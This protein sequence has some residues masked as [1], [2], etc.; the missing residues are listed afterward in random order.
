MDILLILKIVAFLLTF[1]LIIF[2]WL[3]LQDKKLKLF[4]TAILVFF[5]LSIIFF[6]PL[7]HESLEWYKHLLFYIGQIFFYLFSRR[8]IAMNFSFQ[9][10]NASKPISEKLDEFLPSSSK[11]FCV[12]ASAASN[13]SAASTT[14]LSQWFGFLIDQGLLH[15]LTMPLFLLTTVFIRVRY[16]YFESE[17]LKH[18]L[19]FFMLAAGT[20]VMIHVSEFIVESQKLIPVIDPFGEF[21]EMVEFFWF[22]LGLLFFSIGIRK[23]VK[24]QS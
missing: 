17:I 7:S 15:V 13:G 4:F 8:V 19:N 6:F 9:E 10:K 22:Y 5:F 3:K 18:I 23:I 20:F 1:S 12:T 2:G 21:I 14:A 24:F 16:I 11:I